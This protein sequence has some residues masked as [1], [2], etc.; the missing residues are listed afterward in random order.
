M[1]LVSNVYFSRQ[2]V[3]GTR[4]CHEPISGPAAGLLEEQAARA[5]ANRRIPLFMSAL[6]PE[7]S[8]RCRASHDSASA[9]RSG[10]L[11][12]IVRAHSRVPSEVLERLRKGR[13]AGSRRH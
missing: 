4:I 8:G 7:L 1:P 6:T 11:E 12:R 10:P 13:L 3:L 5:A 9:H 2:L